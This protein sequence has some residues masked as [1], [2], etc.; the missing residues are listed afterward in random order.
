MTIKVDEFKPHEPI[1][2][3]KILEEKPQ[4]YAVEIESW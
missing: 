4:I 2:G 1:E 3:C